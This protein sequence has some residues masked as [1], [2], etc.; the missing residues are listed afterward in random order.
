M[1]ERERDRQTD[2]QTDRQRDTVIVFFNQLTGFSLLIYV[3]YFN[4][5]FGAAHTKHCS[6]KI[7]TPFSL[8]LTHFDMKAIQASKKPSQQAVQ[9]LLAGQNIQ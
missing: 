7:Y 1:L 8:F 6:K 2:R 5:R 4:Q 9:H 3:V